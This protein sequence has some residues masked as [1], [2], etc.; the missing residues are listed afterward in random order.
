VIFYNATLLTSLY[1]HYQQVD[2]EMVKAILRF[3]LVAWQHINFI[4]K[5]AFYN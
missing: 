1:L 3:S 5:Y 4:G 2:H